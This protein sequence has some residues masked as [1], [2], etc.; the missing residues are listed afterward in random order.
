LTFLRKF[1]ESVRPYLKAQSFLEMRRSEEG[2]EAHESTTNTRESTKYIETNSWYA[3]CNSIFIIGDL[4]K[5]RATDGLGL[6]FGERTKKW[7]LLP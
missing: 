7:D 3:D 6:Q 1:T 4:N 2:F 5:Y